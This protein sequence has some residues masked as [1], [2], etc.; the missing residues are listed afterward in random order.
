MTKSKS[1]FLY[2]LGREAEFQLGNN[3]MT[4]VNQ[5][6]Q[7]QTKSYSRITSD[8]KLITIEAET[9]NLSVTDLQSRRVI[10]QLQ[11]Y[12]DPPYQFEKFRPFRYAKEDQYPVWKKGNQS[13]AILNPSNF[14][15]KAEFQQF[16]PRGFNPMFVCVSPAKNKILGYS[17]LN[18]DAVLSI[19]HLGNNIQN[20]PINQIPMNPQESWV[21]MEVTT[22]GDILIAAVQKGRASKNP[23]ESF[24]K[25]CA[26][27]VPQSP[28]EQQLALIFERGFNQPAFRRVQMLRK[29]KGYDI[30]MLAC[31][32][33]LA[34]VA[35][36]GQDFLLLNLI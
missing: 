24:L 33:N 23:E 19:V 28:Q 12:K 15:Q 34:F 27:T 10:Q 11:G 2:A 8:E 22:P 4:L 14:Q 29:V 1:L 17:M 6:R 5:P 9:N 13:L 36:N 16:W 20:S 21:G 30:F 26:F 7:A 25:L 31:S 3:L 18:R 32:S 35:F